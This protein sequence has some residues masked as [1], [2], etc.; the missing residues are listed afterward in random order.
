[1][2]SLTLD[3]QLRTNVD[4]DLCQACQVIW[5]D[6]FESLRLSPGS[7]L[8]LFRIIGERAKIAPERLAD[9]LRCP[10][11]KLRLA[12]VRDRQRSTAFRYWRCSRE[13]GRLITFFEFLREK[14]FVRPLSPQ[15]LAELRAN[16]QTINCSNCGAPIDL[17]D[18]SECKHC[19]SSVS[20]LDVKQIERLANKLR[21]ADAASKG[22]IDPTLPARLELEKLQ[23]DT[24][25]KELRADEAWHHSSSVGLVE[26]GLWLLAKKLS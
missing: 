20:M 25:F 21:E 22:P 11:C 15:Q 1:M 5:F 24:L 9:P 17:V 16:V 14:D 2:T 18:G 13:H 6:R 7:I 26:A 12:M 8:R 23:V 10:R 19:G 4:V 3:G